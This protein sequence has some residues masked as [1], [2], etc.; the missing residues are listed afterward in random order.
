VIKEA[1]DQVWRDEP[2]TILEEPELWGVENL[3]AH[4]IDIRLVIKTQPS[5][6]WEISRLIR[7]RIKAAFDERGIEIPFPQ[8]T[9]WM[10]MDGQGGGTSQKTWS[11]PAAR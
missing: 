4:G 1:A 7:E 11:Q 6:Q 9:V 8:Q 10:R 3:G 2:E 5:K